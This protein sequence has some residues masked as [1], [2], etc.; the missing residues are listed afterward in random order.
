MQCQDP[1]SFAEGSW[2][3]R[4]IVGGVGNTV[5]LLATSPS[6]VPCFSTHLVCVLQHIGE[7]PVSILPCRYWLAAECLMHVSRSY[8]GAAWSLQTGLFRQD[9]VGFVRLFLAADADAG[10][11]HGSK[12]THFS[13][14]RF[15]IE[16]VLMSALCT[17]QGNTEVRALGSHGQI[18]SIWPFDSSMLLNNTAE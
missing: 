13:L 14:H 18:R 16:N 8:N 4:A 1:Q 2:Q 12:C 17:K 5:Y 15:D 6:A 3:P 7:L 11:Y 9:A 10:G